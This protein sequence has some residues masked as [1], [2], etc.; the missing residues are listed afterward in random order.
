MSKIEDG[1]HAHHASMDDSDSISELGL[2]QGAM[3]NEASKAEDRN[4]V[5]PPFAKLGGVISGSPAEDAGLKV[6]DKIRR[7]GNVNWMN[8]EKLSKV[9]ETV[10]K[11][12]G[13][14]LAILLEE[15]SFFL[16]LHLDS[17]LSLSRCYV[18]DRTLHSQKSYGS[19]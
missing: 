14:S 4:V 7:F 18:K 16:I 17:K 13:V 6:G 11:N 5:E 2:S 3:P 10:Q 15:R 1:L 12:E 19:N 8:H 9:A